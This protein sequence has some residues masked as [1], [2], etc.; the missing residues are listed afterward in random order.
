MNAPVQAPARPLVSVVMSVYDGAASLAAT[1]DSVLAQEGVDFEFIVVNDGSTDGSGRLLDDY[2]A[3]D[4][5]VRVIHQENTGLTRALIRGCAEARGEFIARQDCGDVSLPGRFAAQATLLAERND[6][7]LTSCAVRTVAPCGALMFVSV[8]EGDTLHHGLTADS[9]EGL[10]GPP[11]HGATMFRRSAYF[12]CGQYNPEYVVAQDL[13]LWLRIVQHGRAYG[14]SNVGYEAEFSPKGISGRRRAEQERMKLRAFREA[15]ARAGLGPAV[16]TGTEVTQALGQESPS[17]MTN[18]EAAAAYFIGSCL[19]DRRDYR[20]ARPYLRAAAQSCP[21]D[22][23][24]R[25]KLWWT[26]LA[27]F[28]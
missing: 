18:A 22:L 14:S 4:A 3:R 28:A 6:V 27:R 13:D 15:R 20:A 21:M 25:L 7:V 23:R 11:H 5:R 12:A 8:R 10:I 1:M 26:Y 2:A 9:I 17:G 19:L 16:P 24:A